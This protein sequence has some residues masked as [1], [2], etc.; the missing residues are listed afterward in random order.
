MTPLVGVV[1]GMLGV[2][3]L[4]RRVE[5]LDQPT[6]GPMKR[7]YHEVGEHERVLVGDACEAADALHPTRSGHLVLQVARTGEK[8]L[9][10][11]EHFGKAWELR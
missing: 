11:R 6:R 8:V 10:F 5:A 9:L 3:A 4:W 2:I 1:V 7:V